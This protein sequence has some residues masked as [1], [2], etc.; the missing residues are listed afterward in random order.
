MAKIRL[1]VIFGS[2]ACEHDVSIISALQ[3]MDAVDSSQY[4]VIPIY[5]SREGAWYIGDRLRDIAFMR[6]FS[7]DAEGITRVFPDVTAGSGALMTVERKR[8]LF[9][10]SRSLVI[11]ARLDV[12]HLVLHGLHGED[13]SVQGLLELMNVPYTSSGLV[14]SAV[15]M[16]KIA[17]R[18]LFRG[19]GFPVLDAAWLTRDEWQNNPQ[20][21]IRHITE[22][23]SYPVYVKPANLGSSIGISRAADEDALREAIE[24]ALSY[25]RRVIVETGIENPVEVNCSVVGF[26]ADVRASVCE[27]PVRWEEFLTFEE[28]YLSGTKSSKGTSADG[29]KLEGGMASLKRKIPAPISEKLTADIQAL[30][31]DIFKALDCKGVVRIDFMLDGD[32]LYVGEINTIPGSLAFYLWEPMGISYSKL[33][34]QMVEYAYKAHAEKNQSVFAFDSNLLTQ[35]ASGTKGGKMGSKT[36]KKLP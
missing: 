7:P 13:G 2:R 9:S 23:L 8:N 26:G 10:T 29:S 31:I 21:V 5:I 17:M 11:I 24:V 36:G 3:C 15:G 25:D 4:E 16:D 33:I 34:D 32:T 18:Q 30:S 20:Q 12:A 6:K 27:M 22:K 1:G 28:K 19:C 14:G 35:M